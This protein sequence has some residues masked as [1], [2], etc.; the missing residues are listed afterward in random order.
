MELSPVDNTLVTIGEI[1]GVHGIQGNLK[2]RSYAQSMSLFRREEGITLLSPEG[3]AQQATV[4]WLKPHGRGLLMA[5]KGLDNRTGAQRLVGMRICIPRRCLPKLEADTYYWTDLVGCEVHTREKA[6]LG[7]VDAIIATGGNDVLVVR[8]R[9][10]GARQEVL[11]PTLADIVVGIDLAAKRLTVELP[12]GLDPQ[13][14]S[15]S[16]AS[17]S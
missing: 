4:H 14:E 9:R 8:D 15:N 10:N 1:T 11:I 3:G 2:V 13:G 5:L 16:G 12:E 6:F 7:K 17:C